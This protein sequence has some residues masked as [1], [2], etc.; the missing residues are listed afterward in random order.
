MPRPKK[1]RASGYRQPEPGESA[2]TGGGAFPGPGEAKTEAG[3]LRRDLLPVILLVLLTAAIRLPLVDI[4]FER[5]EGEYAY[6]AWRLEANEL[7]YRDWVD[8]KPPAVFWVYR[9]ALALPFDP[10]RS[11]HLL[12]MC[13]SACTAAAMFF[14]AR[15]LL[16]DGWAEPGTAGGGLNSRFAAGGQQS[17]LPLALCAPATETGYALSAAALFALLS[18]QPSL[19]GTAANTELFMLLPL[20]LAQLAFLLGVRGGRAETGL[21]VLCGA[22]TSVAAAFK[23]VGAVNWLFLLAVYPGFVSQTGRL[24][25]TLVFAGSL[26]LG[27]I[28]VWGPITAYFAWQR[29]LGDFISNVFTHNLEYVN[30]LRWPER[31]DNCFETI[32]RLSASQGIAW[33]LGAI[34]LCRLWLIGRK[35]ACFFLAGW[36]ATSALGV[37]ASGYFFPHYFQQML[38]ALALAASLGAQTIY[39]AGFWRGAPAWSRC[40][41][42]IALLGILPILELFPFLCRYTPAEAV[43]RIYPG[44]IFAEM[45]ALGRRIAQITNPKDRVFIFGAEPEALFYARRVSATRYIFLFPLYGPYEDVHEKQLAAA[46]EVAAA[47]P[48]AILYYPNRLFFQPGTDHYFTLWTQEYLQKHFRQD[49]LLIATTQGRP[50]VSII[51]GSKDHPPVPPAGHRVLAAIWAKTAE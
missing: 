48:V 42:L 6:I 9:L 22:M 21:L 29:G 37:S 12:A 51:V 15:R 41:A 30:A 18:A 32:R 16:K 4:P 17:G 24:R 10:V 34:G 40:A 11:V 43:R 35:R 27:A 28:C 50:Q 20:A 39:Q 44:N 33:V 38:P 26:A 31:L 25:K 49:A 1:P 47:Q 7:P 46:Q 14:L 13:F 5:D 2:S 23:Q 19:Q 36:L 45:P 3:F 8:Q